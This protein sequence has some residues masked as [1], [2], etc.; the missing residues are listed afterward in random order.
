LSQGAAGG[1][2]DEG[3]RLIGRRV[4]VDGYGEGT[5]VDFHK[6]TIG[7]S[8]H[9]IDFNTP[10]SGSDPG[11]IMPVK[12]QRKGNNQTFWL[13]WPGETE[14]AQ[15]AAVHKQRASPLPAGQ[16]DDPRFAAN[17]EEEYDDDDDVGGGAGPRA[18]WVDAA[19]A[20]RWESQQAA[21]WDTT[22]PGDDPYGGAEYLPPEPEPEPEQ[23]P[24]AEPDLIF[25]G[26]RKPPRRNRGGSG[27]AAAA[28]AAAEQASQRTAAGGSGGGGEAVVST[29][30]IH[31]SLVMDAFIL[32]E[33]ESLRVIAGGVRDMRPGRDDVSLPG[34]QRRGFRG[35]ELTHSSTDNSAGSCGCSE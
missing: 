34:R 3:K 11:L 33:R 16:E 14:A 25:V 12:L 23:P 1:K 6:K 24:Q 30:A 22:T 8:T 32:R 10:G 21:A 2:W 9:S 28:A 29:S 17:Y 27:A 26:K 35:L 7:A 31:Q 13:V 18:A 15:R 4:F 20:E 5:V 19:E